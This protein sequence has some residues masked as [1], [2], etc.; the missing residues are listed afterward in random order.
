MK[1]ILSG[2]ML[3]LTAVTLFFS[4]CKKEEDDMIPPAISFKTGGSYTAT[5]TNVS[6][7]STVLTGINAAKT[8]DNDL[9]TLFT[10]TRS[11]DNGASSQVYSENLSGASGD[12]YS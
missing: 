8:E 9:L 10:I 3:L 1:S 6:M 4:S 11:Y 2:S 5:N 12:A 7:G